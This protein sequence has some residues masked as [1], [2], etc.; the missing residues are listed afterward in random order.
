V[1]IIFSV[2]INV[3]CSVETVCFFQDQVHFV[4]YDIIFCS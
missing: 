3:K 2:G 1:L 4:A